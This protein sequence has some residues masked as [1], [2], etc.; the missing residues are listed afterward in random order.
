MPAAS[1]LV[2]SDNINGTGADNV[3]VLTW[4]DDTVDGRNNGGHNLGDVGSRV[5]DMALIP[6]G[7]R[8]GIGN[9]LFSPRLATSVFPVLMPLLL[10]YYRRVA[11]S[12]CRHRVKHHI[13]T[14][15]ESFGSSPFSCFDDTNEEANVF[16]DDI[17]IF[18]KTSE[19]MQTLLNVVQE[20]TTCCGMERDIYRDCL[21]KDMEIN[22]QKT[23]LLVI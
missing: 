21:L 7:A 1:G 11:V 15:L 3:V 4:A 2:R 20:F 18:A 9:S 6:L 19:G 16:I 12:T 22:V 10:P 23:F 17:L 13:T 14:L 5:L 8:K